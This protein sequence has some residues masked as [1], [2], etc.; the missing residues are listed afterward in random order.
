MT[1]AALER[2]RA[3]DNSWATASRA[4]PSPAITSRRAAPALAHL[5]HF[6]SAPPRARL[7]KG[8]PSLPPGGAS[9]GGR[10]SP[11]G[12]QRPSPP[13]YVRRRCPSYAPR[14]AST[15][16]LI[17]K[18]PARSGVGHAEPCGDGGSHVREGVPGSQVDTGADGPSPREKRG[19]LPGVV[20]AGRGGVAAVVS[21]QQQRVVGPQRLLNLG[22]PP[23]K[24]FQGGRVPLGIVAVAPKGIEVHAV[25]KQ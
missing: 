9:P 13:P 5:P 25:D 7:L 23:V 2:S 19:A 12:A 21:H 14:E 4:R 16:H 22:Q 10:S 6:R 17:R 18:R 3:A 24:G 15:G 8:D 1:M 20:G 11:S